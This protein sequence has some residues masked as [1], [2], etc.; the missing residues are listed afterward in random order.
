MKKEWQS[1]NWAALV[2]LCVFI[3]EEMLLEEGGEFILIE[4]YKGK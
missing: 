3:R 4:D 2:S 1:E